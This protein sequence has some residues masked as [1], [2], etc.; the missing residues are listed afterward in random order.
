MK[1]VIGLGKTGASLIQYLMNRDYE[2]MAWDDS[3]VLQEKAKLMGAAIVEPAKAPWHIISEVILSPGVPTTFPEPH[4]SVK[5]AQRYG[6]PFRG[7]VDCWAQ[8]HQ[9]SSFIYVGVTGTNGKS[10]THAM[11]DYILQKKDIPVFSGGNSGVPMFDAGQLAPNSIVNLEMSSYQLDITRSLQFHAGVVLNITPDHL[12]RHG[13]MDQY[14]Q[15]KKIQ[16]QRVVPGGLK[17]IGVDSPHSLQA[18]EEL[19]AQG[20]QDIIPISGHRVL[21]RGV[22]AVGREVYTSESGSPVRIGE[23]PEIL[24]GA[25]NAQNAIAAMLVCRHLGVESADF[26]DLLLGYPGLPHRQERVLDTSNAVFIN[27]SKA[28]NADATRPALQAFK[29]IYWI[30]GGIAKEEGVLPLTPCLGNVENVYL[31]GEA[32]DRFQ[33]ELSGHVPHIVMAGTLDRALE[34]IQAQLS[35]V[36]HKVTVLL[37]PACASQDQFKN[38]EHRGHVFKELVH[39]RFGGQ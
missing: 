14:I 29:H 37:S 21:E 25:H 15:S 16:L 11:I 19:L 39:Q 10:T 38:F 20:H 6:I 33:L 2:F 32:A 5:L 26:F 24:P 13:S 31:I 8:F 18:Y 1:Y 9:L 3:P 7:D 17:V 28:T 36:D 30:A 12:D 27:D 4:A 35:T 34:L 23:M 22:Y